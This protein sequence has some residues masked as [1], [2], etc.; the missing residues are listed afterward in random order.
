MNNIKAKYNI[1]IIGAGPSGLMA[2]SICSEDNLKIVIL[3]KMDDLCLKLKLTGKGRCNITNNASLDEF[4]KHFGRQGRFLKHTFSQFF[5]EDLIKYFEKLGVQFKLE[6]GGR[7]FPKSNSAF[8]VADA[9]IKDVKSKGVSILKNSEV[10]SVKKLAEK[11]EV[12]IKSGKTLETDQVIISC[13][14]KSY[15]RTGSSGDGYRLAKSLGHKIIEPKP[16]LTPLITKG[17]AAKI[18]KDCP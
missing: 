12:K 8:D 18:Y 4:I 14:G 9:L 2:A 5:N 16:S 10:I 6:R 7:Y 15:P 3:E 13:G 17:L 1:L 11:F